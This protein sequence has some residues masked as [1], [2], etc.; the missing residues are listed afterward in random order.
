MNKRQNKKLSN[1]GFSLIEIL[2]YIGIL[3]IVSIAFF[4]IL[5]VS[6]RVQIQ[7]SSGSEVANQ[8]NFA[9]QTIERHI[10][11]AS[12][13][14]ISDQNESACADTL[15]RI[16]ETTLP[17]LLE[18]PQPCIKLRMPDDEQDPTCIY[19][20][21]DT[22]KVAQGHISE[23]PDIC[24]RDGSEE[25]L[26]TDKVLVT[27][28]TFT[29]FN[30]FPGHD[31]V[32]INLAMK[33]NTQNPAGELERSLT[34]AVGRASAATFDS[35]ILSP[36]GTLYD[37]GNS[38]Y[39]WDNLF[40]NRIETKDATAN[41]EIKGLIYQPDNFDGVAR[42]SFMIGAS[43]TTCNAVCALH[44]G[45]CQAALQLYNADSDPAFFDMTLNFTLC[46]TS[47][48]TSATSPGGICYCF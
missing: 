31:V 43:N 4:Q 8:M 47:L 3:S 14:I 33:F 10:K 38:T 37:I 29:K 18:K 5:G 19:K 6:T 17:S 32:E 15:D 28:L 21:G 46:T 34:N 12:V 26:V 22:I 41:H 44:T 7:Q 27:D 48:N 9:M 11:D 45:S 39:P 23:N 35:D 40:V 16:E 30:N 42:G 20:E 13:I 24:K 2:V 1:R 36:V 25:A